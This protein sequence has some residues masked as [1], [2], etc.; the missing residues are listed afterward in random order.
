MSIILNLLVKFNSNKVKHKEVFDVKQTK[1]KV[2]FPPERLEIND[3]YRYI[4]H[5]CKSL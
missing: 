2:T 3:W 5:Q 4:Y 1:F